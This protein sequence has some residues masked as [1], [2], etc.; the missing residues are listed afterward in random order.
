MV[1]TKGANDAEQDGTHT[2]Q[3]TA[4]TCIQHQSTAQSRCPESL[5]CCCTLFCHS[6]EKLHCLPSWH[7]LLPDLRGLGS[8][9]VCCPWSPM[10]P[11]QIC[12]ADK[13]CSMPYCAENLPRLRALQMKT[14]ASQNAASIARALDLSRAAIQGAG[15]Q[16]L[17]AMR[18]AAAAPVIHKSCR[19]GCSEPCCLFLLI[20]ILRQSRASQSKAHWLSSIIVI[21]ACHHV[22]RCFRDTCSNVTLLGT[23]TASCTQHIFS[24]HLVKKT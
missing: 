7:Y 18:G 10:A 3:L 6:R 1:E 4:T 13:N 22:P 12:I 11:Q 8:D 15:N 2:L 14:C 9:W 24:K 16:A 17:A 19:N 23:S 5:Y 20:L 21:L